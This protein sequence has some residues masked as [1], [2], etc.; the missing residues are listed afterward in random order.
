MQIESNENGTTVLNAHRI[1]YS[2]LKIGTV[3]SIVSVFIIYHNIF[4]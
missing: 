4:N 1:F 3:A 2:E